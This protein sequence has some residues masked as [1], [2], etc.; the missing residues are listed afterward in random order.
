MKSVRNREL[1]SYRSLTEADELLKYYTD[2]D[3]DGV[4]KDIVS[5]LNGDRVP[6]LTTS[7][8]NDMTSIR[9]KDDVLTLL[10]HFSYLAYN[11]DW[12]TVE[13]PDAEV[14]M[15]FLKIISY[16]TQKQL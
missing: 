5:M 2:I 10:I 8:Q 11:R 6:V 16:S 15:H 13:I 14:R 4:Q 1:D 12:Q 9:Y 3:F 7:F